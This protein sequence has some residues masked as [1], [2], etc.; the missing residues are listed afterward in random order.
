[1]SE[2]PASENLPAS[3]IFILLRNAVLLSFALVPQPDLSPQ[4]CTAPARDHSVSKTASV[5]DDITQNKR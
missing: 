1:M 4:S 3:G 2:N 5:K